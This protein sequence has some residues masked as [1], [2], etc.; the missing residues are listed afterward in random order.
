MAESFPIF[1]ICYKNLFY[2]YL[3]SIIIITAAPSA[4]GV[5]V[6]NAIYF[7][8]PTMEN[9]DVY[10]AL[11]WV[12]IAPRSHFNLPR[13]VSELYLYKMVP[14]GKRGGPPAKR[15]L[16]K[17][18][19]TIPDTNGWHHFDITDLAHRWTAD[20][21]SNLGIVVEA[22]DADNENLIIL[23]PTTGI[24]EGY[25]SIVCLDQIYIYIMPW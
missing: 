16:K 24:N 14:P 19:K 12:Y 8:M 6:S 22:I 23:P 21:S 1:V 25:V 20:S 3:I 17:R 9:R 5:T 13:N 15:F 11:L 4:V 18:K 2:I 10:K 7:N